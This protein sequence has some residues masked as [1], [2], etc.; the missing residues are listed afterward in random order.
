MAPSLDEIGSDWFSEQAIELTDHIKHMTPVEY[1]EQH[2]YLPKGVT[3]ME[4]YMSFDVNPFMREVL[5][6]FDVDSPV[7]EVNFMK[8]VQVTY[9]TVAESIML[10]FM[11]HVKTDPMMFVSASKELVDMRVENNILPMLAQSNLENLIQSSDEGN[12]RKTGKNKNQLQGVGGWILYPIGAQSAL[13]MRQNSVRVMIKDEVDGWPLIVGKD[14]DP[15]QL[16]NDRCSAYESTRKIFR[17]ST[18]L[19]EHRS[20]IFKA[21]KRGDQRKYFVLCKSCSYPQELWWKHENKETGVISAFNWE[22][23]NGM[24]IPESVCYLCVNCQHAHYE[25]DKQVLFAEDHGAHWKPTATPAERD[26]RSYHL[27][28]MYSPLG[29]RTWAKCVSQ[30]LEA[31]DPVTKKTLDVG[32]YQVFR[33]NILGLPFRVQGARVTAEHVSPHKREEYF[34]GQIP[35]KYAAEWCGSHILMLICTVDVHK[36]NLRV[37]IWGITRGCRIFLID[38]ITIETTEEQGDFTDVDYPG[39]NDLDEIIMKKIY[40]ADDGKKYRIAFTLIDSGYSNVTVCTF[41]SQYASGVYPILGRDRPAKN[42][43]IKEFEQFTTQLQTTGYKIVVDYY[44]DRTAPVLRR[45]W[46]PEDGPQKTYHFNVPYDCTKAQLKELTVEVREERV[47]DK[48]NVSYPWTRPSGADNTMFDLLQYL[49]AGVDI[50]AWLICVQ[51]F[52]FENINWPV[53]WD[54]IQEETLYYED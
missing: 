1:S 6:C 23:E 20:L 9:T 18:P 30:F 48:G 49:C 22:L 19:I 13:K 28:A 37:A 2:R 32:K 47:D 10:Y 33:N 35:N 25:H 45:E 11:G 12:K 3:S 29:M 41:C 14:G 26:I 5:N 43:V 7:R 39:W 42:A 53:F 36:D 38:Y 51:H 17:G 8:G 16:T 4:G 46:I 54:H 21:Y 40:V 27:P 24:L 15:E 52:E 44:K 31:Y 50:V 34:Y